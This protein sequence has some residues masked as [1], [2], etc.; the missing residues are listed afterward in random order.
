MGFLPK[1]SE[2]G[3]KSNGPQPR[4]RN[5]MVMSNWALE[6]SVMPISIPIRSSAGRTAS[7]ARATIDIREAIKAMNSRECCSD[8]FCIGKRYNNADR[9]E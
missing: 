8:R 2:S 9:G 7:I 5:I 3:P 4:P 6:A 1:A